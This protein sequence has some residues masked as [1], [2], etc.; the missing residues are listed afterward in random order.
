[1]IK[2]YIFQEVASFNLLPYY[3]FA[4]ANLSSS[5]SQNSLEVI[6]G[7]TAYSSKVSPHVEKY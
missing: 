3:L 4:A 7:V 2:V 6:F 5:V 1:M